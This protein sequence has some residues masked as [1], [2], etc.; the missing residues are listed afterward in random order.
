MLGQSL[1]RLYPRDLCPC[2][3]QRERTIG[4][5]PHW[6]PQGKSGDQMAHRVS[7]MET[8]LYKEVEVAPSCP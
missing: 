7:A 8:T 2:G 5:P 4:L 1:Q 3:R 6:A